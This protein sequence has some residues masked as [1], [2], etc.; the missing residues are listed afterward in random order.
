MFVDVSPNVQ[1]VLLDMNGEF[2]APIM[3]SGLG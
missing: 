3:Q 2:M 1:V